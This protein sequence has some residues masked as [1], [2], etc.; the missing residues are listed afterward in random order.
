M[1]YGAIVSVD[2]KFRDEFYGM[3]G[4][5]VNVCHVT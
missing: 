2:E 4:V 1:G 3:G 5:Y